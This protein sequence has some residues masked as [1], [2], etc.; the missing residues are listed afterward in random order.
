[1]IST[2]QPKKH[3]Y[4]YLREQTEYNQDHDKKKHIDNIWRADDNL[5]MKLRIRIMIRSWG[6]FHQN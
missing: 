6:I 1:M 4:A 2:A 3:D 5:L